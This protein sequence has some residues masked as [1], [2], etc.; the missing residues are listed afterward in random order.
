MQNTDKSSTHSWAFDTRLWYAPPK[1]LTSAPSFSLAILSHLRNLGHD[2]A[3][4]N[5]ALPQ[6]N[7]TIGTSWIDSGNSLQHNL[8]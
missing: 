6:D 1:F 7:E 4:R 3:H 2:A 5:S 8:R